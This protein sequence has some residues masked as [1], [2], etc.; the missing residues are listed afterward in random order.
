LVSALDKD[1]LSAEVA[2]NKSRWYARAAFLELFPARF[3]SIALGDNSLQDCFVIGVGGWIG[4][5]PQNSAAC[6][7][8]VFEVV[9]WAAVR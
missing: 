5:T 9:V 8:Q 3:Q 2:M 7:S 1:V 4:Q 6:R